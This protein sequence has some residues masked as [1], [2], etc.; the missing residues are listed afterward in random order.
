MAANKIRVL[1]VDDEPLAR[2]GMWQ[3]LEPEKDF[4][5]VAE[6]ANGHEA[7]SAIQKYSPDLVF[8][9]VQMPLL[10]GF[11][12]IQKAGVENL[13]ELVFV[14]AY[15][16][17]AIRAFEVHALDYLLKPIDKERFQKTLK[18]VRTGI[19]TR[20]RNEMDGGI[21]ALLSELESAK[22]NGGQQGYLSRIAVK[23]A[24]RINFVGVDEIDWISSDG[25]YVKLHTKSKTHHLR[26]TMDGLEHKLDPQKFLRLRRSVIV[27]IDQISELHPLFNGEYAV[28]LKDKTELSSSRRYRR[29]LNLLLKS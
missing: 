27:C 10:D 2:R 17:Y 13:P 22:S 9:D 6:A 3:L 18:R 5:V 4:E 15:D 11:S 29:N 23:E 25:N 14:T 24:G 7:I 19:K 21:S 20:K 16:E 12:V 26:E 1:I 28:I 8:L